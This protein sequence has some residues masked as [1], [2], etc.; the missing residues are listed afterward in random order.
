M[1]CTPSVGFPQEALAVKTKTL[2]CSLSPVFKKAVILVYR[3][4]N[5]LKKKMV[6]IVSVALIYSHMPQMVS[7]V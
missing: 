5:K 7:L 4:N 3:E 2:M 6:S 1:G